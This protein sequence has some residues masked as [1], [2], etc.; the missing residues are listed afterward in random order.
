MLIESLTIHGKA[1][2][3][4]AVFASFERTDLSKRFAPSLRIAYLCTKVRRPPPP[5]PPRPPPAPPGPTRVQLP[6][7][8]GPIC[9][10]HFSVSPLSCK[11]CMNKGFKMSSFS[12]L[13]CGIALSVALSVARQGGQE[14]SLASVS[15]DVELNSAVS[16]TLTVC[17][18]AHFGGGGGGGK[19]ASLFPRH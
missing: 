9:S 12:D 3:N 5:P 1:T 15:V 8:E 2:G 13:T 18:L 17:R 6:R 7:W 19:I 10:C 11:F 4:R 16:S 14:G